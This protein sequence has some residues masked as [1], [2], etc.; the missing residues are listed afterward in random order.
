MEGLLCLSG[1]ERDAASGALDHAERWVVALALIAVVALCSATAA[2]QAFA[3]FVTYDD[4]GYMMMSVRH[5]LD[6]HRLYG[7]IQIPYGPLYY[8]EKWVL[9]G[10][11]DVPLT[12]ASGRA[13]FVVTRMLTA[14]VGAA[15]VA[16][17]SHNLPMGVVAFCVLS[18]HQ[19]ILTAEP[20]HPQELGVLLTAALPLCASFAAARPAATLVALGLL[21][22]SLAMIKVNLGAIALVAVVLALIASHAA[23]WRGLAAVAPLGVAALPWL[24]VGG[25]RPWRPFAACVTAWIAGQLPWSRA[26]RGADPLRGWPLVLCA[27]L[28]GG[29]A[30]FVL[31][32]MRFGASPEEILRAL[33]IEPRRAFGSIG[34]LFVPTPPVGVWTAAGLA[35]SVGYSIL[36]C[37]QPT[38]FVQ[39]RW[40]AMLA[41]SAVALWHPRGMAHQLPFFIGP[42][43]WVLLLREGSLARAL[44]AWLTVLAPLQAFP[45]PGT[46]ATC[47]ALPAVVCVT[48]IIGDLIAAGTARLGAVH[49]RW[50][51][52][53]SAAALLLLCVDSSWRDLR[54]AR[55]IYAKG[56]ALAIPGTGPLHDENAATLRAMTE[57]IRPRCDVLLTLPGFQSMNFWSATRPPTLDLVSHKSRHI[58]D[59]RLAAIAAGLRAAQSPCVLCRG[60]AGRPCPGSDLWK[61]PPDARI[62]AQILAALRPVGSWPP[63]TL[64]A[65]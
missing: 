31:V 43:A 50:L 13:T 17:L 8:L 49:G 41:V 32:A 26:Q 24:L 40:V 30:F 12:H 29:T 42:W 55:T 28:A 51:W 56:D 36:R 20:G 11:L 54:L 14:A 4:E 64:Y 58:S 33:V 45:I 38:H 25:Y 18:S 59:A 22:A 57:A 7:E 48:V 62:Q 3:W 23:T 53:L 35:A 47:G 9:H 27:G 16:R 46:Q 61:E 1:M 19:L 63:Y 37:R 39:T 44:T 60:N 21:S 2:I 6:G 34:D 5:L 52:R 65:R 15:T 10:W